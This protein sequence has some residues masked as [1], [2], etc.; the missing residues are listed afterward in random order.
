MGFLKNLYLNGKENSTKDKKRLADLVNKKNSSSYGILYDIY[1]DL[2]NFVNN[3]PVLEN[4]LINMAYAYSRRAVV[5]FMYL[6]GQVSL[7][8]LNYNNEIFKTI[9]DRTTIQLNQKTYEDTVDFQN[10]AANQA[11][12]F[13]LSYS[14]KYTK[15]LFIAV[16][17]I[18]ETKNIKLI[19]V[20]QDLYKDLNVDSSTANEVHYQIIEILDNFTKKMNSI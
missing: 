11:F 14:Y 10:E 19:E 15:N 13:L 17:S 16:H 20:L 6:Q 18:F 7:E 4:P 3:Y 2:G 1:Q 9:Q 5:E 8:D 12:E